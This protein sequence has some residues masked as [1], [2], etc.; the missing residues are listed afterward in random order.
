MHA[1]KTEC[2]WKT[3]FSRT[4]QTNKQTKKQTNKQTRKVLFWCSFQRVTSAAQTTAHCVRL[5][6]TRTSSP[7]SRASARRA[8]PW[9]T[10]SISMCP[11][12]QTARTSTTSYSAPSPV[13]S[14]SIPSITFIT[15]K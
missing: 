4:K 6:K 7:A 12:P 1:W 14:V 10:P 15:T 8:V 5:S 11:P 3:T 13:A 2:R 9:S